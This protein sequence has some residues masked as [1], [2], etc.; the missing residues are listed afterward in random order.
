MKKGFTLIEL[1][2]VIL[3][4]GIIALIAIPTVNKIIEESRMGAFKATVNNLVSAVGTACQ[5]EGIKNDNITG[6]YTITNGK[7]SP[8]IDI[9]GEL[10]KEGIVYVSNNCLVTLDANND[11]YNASVNVD[12]NINI[13]KCENGICPSKEIILRNDLTNT[14]KESVELW[15]S[16]Q[17]Q[18]APS[19]GNT[20]FFTSIY[21]KKKGYLN[22]NTK[23]PI[24]N[25]CLYNGTIIEVTNNGG[26]YSY[27]F[28]FSNQIYSS[29]SHCNTVSHTRYAI[30]KGKQYITIN[31]GDAYVDKGAIIFDVNGND[32]NGET[33]STWY[34]KPTGGS[35][36]KIDTNVLGDWEVRLEYNTTSNTSNS[37]RRFI[38]IK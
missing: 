14:I 33:F 21:L 36:S 2:A 8:S 5:V 1:L 26:A 4:L 22:P 37:S 9:K 31:Q 23:D 12:G 17:N 6:I 27:R 3:I 7:I 29:S 11:K 24:S 19:D 25:E 16:E 30:F 20:I 35:S 10:P 15:F 18:F 38:T 32:L 34:Y 28:D 13:D